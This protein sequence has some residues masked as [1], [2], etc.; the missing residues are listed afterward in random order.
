MFY[1]KKY[2]YIILAVLGII[3]IL[4]AIFNKNNDKVED[5][6]ILEPIEQEF[7]EIKDDELSDKKIKI[8]IKGAVKNPGVY[9]LENNSRVNDAIEISGGLTKDADTSVINLSK[10]LTDE[11]VI[12]IYTKDEI[13]EMLKGDTSIKYIEKECICPKLENDACIDNIVD[14]K[15]NNDSSNSS[16]SNNSKVSLNNATID[17]LMQLPGIGEVKA[18]AIINYREENGGFKT[19]EELK[20]VNGIGEATFN[21]IKDQLTL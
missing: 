10:N 1:L 19:I 8:D 18:K 5:D 9:E 3:L 16:S 17:E 21:K 11:M 6:L 4:I 13:S 12:I 20:E 15:P 7:V 2:R 14:N